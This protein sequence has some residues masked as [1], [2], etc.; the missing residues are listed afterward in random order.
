MKLRHVQKIEPL[1]K[2]KKE[3]EN[4]STAPSTDEI[5]TFTE[6]RTSK[7]AETR[8]RTELVS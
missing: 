5:E 6:L 3:A 4:K 7:R 8:T 1:R 2:T